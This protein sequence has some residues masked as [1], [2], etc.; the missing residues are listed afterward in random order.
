M[1]S[2]KILKRS[3]KK[4]GVE[5]F[6]KEILFIFDNP[7]DMWEMELML[8]EENDPQSYNLRKGGSGGF[9]DKAVKNGRLA[10]DKVLEEQYGEN[11]RT[12]LAEKAS[13]G[14]NPESYKKAGAKA[15]QTLLKR[16][17]PKGFRH[18]HTEESKKL[19]GQ[20][21]SIKQK[22]E[23]NSQYGTMWITNG[24]ENKKIKKGDPI[25]ENWKPGRKVKNNGV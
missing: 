15:R 12:V 2:G 5:N 23:S 9:T 11:W 16:Y 13:A 24:T 10:A 6:E 7:E 17:G 4:Y 22:G 25:P 1:G 21:N 20:A 19:I 3:I 8:V 18:P 14:R